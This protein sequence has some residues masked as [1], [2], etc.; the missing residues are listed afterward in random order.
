MKSSA[1]AALMSKI[2]NYVN[3]KMDELEEC[4]LNPNSEVDSSLDFDSDGYDADGDG[5]ISPDEKF[6]NYEEF[7]M[8]SNP[9]QADTDG[10]NCTD[11]WE[12]YWN[13]NRPDNETR[14]FDLLD[15]DDGLIPK[16]NILLLVRLN[17][18]FLI[19]LFKT[20]VFSIK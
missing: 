8:D 17:L 6:T 5:E 15:G 18:L 9:S 10:D 2:S 14:G 13:D 20:F 3:Q 4:G 11:G 7:L 1:D 16:I 19:A 12:I